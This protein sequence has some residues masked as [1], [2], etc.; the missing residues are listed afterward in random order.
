MENRLKLF[1]DAGS[2][3]FINKGYARTQIKDIAKEIN[4]STGMLYQYFTS[5]RDILSFILKCTIDPTVLDNDY[6]F[7]IQSDMFKN[8]D[9]EIKAGFE[10]NQLQ[11]ASHLADQTKGYPLAEMFSDAYDLISK[12]G[13]GCLIIEHN[14]DDLTELAQYYRSYRRKYFQLIKE[15]VEIYI[16]KGEFRKTQ[17]TH[18]TTRAIVEIMAWWGMHVANDAFDIDK[19]ISKENAKEICMD[20]L[21]NAYS[22]S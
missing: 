17:E 22:T 8:L 1:Y 2:R 19:T 15:Y 21:M 20:N 3:L 16:G 9:D 12:Y 6:E 7:P 18:Y 5:K 14:V 4:L 10:E 11:L 13:V